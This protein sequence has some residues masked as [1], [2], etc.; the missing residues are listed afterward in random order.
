MTRRFRVID[1]EVREVSDAI[2][3][4]K[5][6]DA[7]P[8]VSD[9]L[10][11]PE[12]CLADRQAQLEQLRCSGIEFRRDPQVPEFIQVH[13]TSRKALDNYAKM[14]GLTN[15]TG[16]L[17]GGVK[18]SQEDLDRAAALVSRNE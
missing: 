6:G 12:Q 16:R 14:R 13:G 15:R 17:G 10:G 11:F 9:A 4:A 7:A 8:A 1:G 18:L 2:L 3:P 5:T